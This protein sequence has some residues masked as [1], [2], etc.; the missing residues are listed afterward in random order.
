MSVRGRQRLVAVS[1]ILVD[2]QLVIAGNGGFG[3]SVALLT[4]EVVHG[5]GHGVIR[6]RSDA[7]DLVAK[8]FAVGKGG[9]VVRERLDALDGKR[10]DLQGG[11]V[12]QG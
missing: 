11:S 7:F 10:L 9:I 12:G 5:V 8:L 6:V 3:E 2:V 4:E 1:V